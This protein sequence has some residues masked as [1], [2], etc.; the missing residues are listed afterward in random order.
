[1]ESEISLESDST[2]VKKLKKTVKAGKK[3][4]VKKSAGKT[5]AKKGK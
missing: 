1:M 2:P 5:K 3:K 4:P